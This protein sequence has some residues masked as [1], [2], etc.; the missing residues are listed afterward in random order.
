MKFFNTLMTTAKP[1]SLALL[2]SA[3]AHSDTLRDFVARHPKHVTAVLAAVLL[4]GGGGAFAVANL[5]PDAA[6]LPVRT[7]VET[8]S[9]PNLDAQ[10]EALEQQTL[11]LYRNDITRG[12]DTAESL[13]R[14]LGLVDAAAAAYIRKTPEVRQALLNRSGR[15]VSVEANEQQQLLTLTTRWLKNDNDSQFQRM[16][17]T[18]DADNKFSVRTDTAPLTASVRMSGGT[19]NSSLYEASDEARLPETVTRQLADVFSGQIDFH[20]ALRKGAVFSVVYETLEAEGEPLRAG[21]LLSAEITNDQKTYNAVWFQEPGQK[22]AYYTL[23]GDSLRRAFL[24]SPVPYSRRTSGFGM[25]EHPILHT[26]RAHLGVDYAAPTGTP[27]MSVADGVVVE[28][29][30]Q[31]AF[32]NMVVVQHNARQSTVYAH[33]SRMNVKRGQTIKQGDIVGAVGTTGLS[34]GPHLHFEFRINGRHVDPLTLAQQ[35]SSEPISA[36]QRNQF[37]QRAE[38]AR[39]QLMAAAQMRQNNVQ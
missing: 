25:R 19:V 33:L 16:V 26:Q 36:A 38:F 7:L 11:K 8:L 24:A 31:G 30:F 9:T 21:R 34:T 27:V 22:G 35:G 10:V 4:G 28:S 18:R 20:R 3:K 13:L 12:S 32:G 23:K 39:A 17:I 6:N 14:R 15:N 2:A 1:F 29:G 37:N 5:G